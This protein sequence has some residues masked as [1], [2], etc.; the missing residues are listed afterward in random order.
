MGKFTSAYMHK[1]LDEIKLIAPI[2]FWAVGE[3]SSHMLSQDLLPEEGRFQIFFVQ[4]EKLI[5]NSDFREVDM[6]SLFTLNEKNNQRISRIISHWENFEYLDPPKIHYDDFTKKI[7][8]EDGR[9]RAKLSFY[10]QFDSIP[11]AIHVN[12]VYE[13]NK[14]VQL[15]RS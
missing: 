13:I 2:A 9:H 7:N 8:F 6:S 12:D 4:T 15:F 14:L 3:Y 10:L 5:E 11:V 1:T